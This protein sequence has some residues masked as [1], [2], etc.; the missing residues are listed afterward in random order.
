MKNN[1]TPKLSR[2]IT[3]GFLFVQLLL[4]AAC[5]KDDELPANPG[6]QV[7]PKVQ[8]AKDQYQAGEKSAGMFI[9][10][11]LKSRTTLAGS[12]SVKLESQTAVYGTDYV[13]QPEAISG[14]IQLP[15]A[16]GSE[17]VSLKVIPINNDA[18]NN[19]REI[20]FTLLAE[21]STFKPEGRIQSKILIEDDE[22]FSIISF[23]ETTASIMEN[24]P[25]GY[26]VQLAIAPQAAAAGFIEIEL[27][28]TNAQYNQHYYTLPEAENGKLRLPVQQG[29]GNVSFV[30]YA[31]DNLQ[32]NTV[33]KVKFK[34]GSASENLQSGSAS[35]MNFFIED[36][37]DNTGKS[38]SYIRDIFT[39]NAYVINTTTR[40][41]GVVTSYNDNLDAKV[42]Y[43]EDATGGIAIRF[44]NVHSFNAGDMVMID[45][46]GSILSE[47][48][49]IL[50]I[51]QINNGAATRIGFQT[52]NIPATSPS[53]LYHSP[54]ILE[55]R[56]VTLENVRF[57][58][59]DGFTQLRGDQRITDGG[60]QVIVRTEHFSSFASR[61]IPAGI[62]SV[63]GI[64]VWR[65]NEYTIYPQK[66][67]D[68]R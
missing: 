46:N 43:V 60:R 57:I 25:A 51:S 26:T 31:K 58:N 4:L 11:D 55:G 5:S 8:F 28:S 19:E 45:L 10:I 13:T 21:E 68:I 6:N 53:A 56:I 34:L 3:G 36:N 27:N 37:D 49:G 44:T 23:S 38:I 32:V 22:T 7:A 17:K 2:L 39:G 61:I 41:T 67:N 48:N 1:T 42:M 62:V 16:S 65:N 64:L 50:N 20:T 15:V 54:E 47:T 59:A 9:E 40:I 66:S 24:S 30:M 29:S 33:R 14:K 12:I 63:T 52:K 35:E 18:R